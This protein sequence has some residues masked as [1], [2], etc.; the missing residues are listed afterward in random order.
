M[1]A[2]PSTNAIVVG[3]RLGKGMVGALAFV[4]T[5]VSNA[6]EA[7]GLTLVAVPAVI[8]KGATAGVSI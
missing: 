4:N 7:N 8:M 6:P 3:T 2:T 1:S 5:S